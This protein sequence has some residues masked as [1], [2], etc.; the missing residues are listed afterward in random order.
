V[1]ACG[2]T[3]LV[4]TDKRTIQSETVWNDGAQGGA[5]GGGISKIFPVPDWQTGLSA[6]ESSGSTTPLSGRGVPDV[7]ADADPGTGYTVLVDGQTFAIGGTS[8]VAP[9]LA[10][11]VAILNQELGTP[12]GFLN[13]ELYKLGGTS[14]LRDIISGNNGTFAAATGW[15]ACTGLG[16][17]LGT[18]LLSALKGT[19]ATTGR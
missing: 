8:A 7:A 17:P 13:P 2:G 19:Q 6:A 3:S 14:A 12:V 4:S 1:T 11:L 9:L 10:G 16:A 18:A 15:D 5:T